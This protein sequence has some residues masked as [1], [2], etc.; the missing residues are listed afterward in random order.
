MQ[1][2]HL[3]LDTSSV[4][5]AIVN[6]YKSACERYYGSLGNKS[7]KNKNISLSYDGT[8]GQSGGPAEI[9]RTSPIAM[10]KAVKNQAELE[11]MCGSHLR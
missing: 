9:C 3:W 11:G 4:N 2:A 5:A 1:G 10:A 6:T 7:N 8:N